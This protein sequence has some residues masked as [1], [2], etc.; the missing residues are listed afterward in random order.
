MEKV[1]G[2]C[3][4]MD[5]VELAVNGTLMRGLELEKNLLNVNAG[6]FPIW[7]LAGVHRKSMEKAGL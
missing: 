5:F 2:M 6:N 3:S 4:E 7:R 1:K